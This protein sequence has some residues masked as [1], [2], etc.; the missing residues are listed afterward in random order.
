M[1]DQTAAWKTA[2]DNRYVFLQC[3]VLMSK[4]MLRAL[5]AGEFHDRQW[6]RPE[7]YCRKRENSV[8]SR[9]KKSLHGTSI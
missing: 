4:N 1:F 3:Y 7:K 6:V 9:R 5:E 8:I 2:A